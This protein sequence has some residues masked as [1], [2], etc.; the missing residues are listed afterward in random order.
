MHP[1]SEVQYQRTAPA[2][3]ALHDALLRAHAAHDT[4]ADEEQAEWLALLSREA[5]AELNLTAVWTTKNPRTGE[6][7][8]AATAEREPVV[9]RA[10]MF[11]HNVMRQFRSRWHMDPHEP[12][13][14]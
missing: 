2:A 13:R 3:E 8:P 4:P 14:H 7:G 10:Q 11:Q 12:E 9:A 1:R 5:A 6:A